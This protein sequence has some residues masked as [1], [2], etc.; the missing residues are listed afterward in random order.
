[1]QYVTR[2][3]VFDRFAL[4]IFWSAVFMFF[5]NVLPCFHSILLS[6]QRLRRSY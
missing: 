1:M 6:A 5:R 2:V 4:L 3:F